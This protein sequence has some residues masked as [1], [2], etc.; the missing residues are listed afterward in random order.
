M[1]N[2]TSCAATRRR[3]GCMQLVKIMSDQKEDIKMVVTEL[4]GAHALPIVEFL[5][6][7]E[8]ISEFIVAEELN[9][10]IKRDEEHLE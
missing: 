8:K 9:M 10:E 7:K 4:V 2:Y 6:G 5:Q 3:R 1:N